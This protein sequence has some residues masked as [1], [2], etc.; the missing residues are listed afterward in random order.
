MEYGECIARHKAHNIKPV[1]SSLVEN[2]RVIEFKNDCE[3]ETNFYK[4]LLEDFTRRI[5]M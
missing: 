5:K 3:K 4:F 1:S 2:R